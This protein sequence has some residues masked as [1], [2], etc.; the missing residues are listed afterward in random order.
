MQKK[1]DERAKPVTGTSRS[2]SCRRY[3]GSRRRR[4]RG[5]RRAAAAAAAR[6]DQL[7]VVQLHW[8]HGDAQPGLAQPPEKR[9]WSLLPGSVTAPRRARSESPPP[10]AW[11][12]LL[13]RKPSPGCGGPPPCRA[14]R[15]GRGEASADGRMEGRAGRRSRER[16]SGTVQRP[17]DGWAAASMLRGLGRKSPGRTEGE[18]AGGLFHWQPVTVPRAVPG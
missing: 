3:R 11:P 7:V 13:N 15:T 4:S 2:R 8:G 14:G 12:P 18:H 16:A 1:F 9:P 5:C 17:P 10:S 6:R